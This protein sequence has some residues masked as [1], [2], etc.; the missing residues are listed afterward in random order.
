MK[1]LRE[2]EEEELTASKVLNGSCP[3]GILLNISPLVMARL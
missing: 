2:E 1:T 3:F